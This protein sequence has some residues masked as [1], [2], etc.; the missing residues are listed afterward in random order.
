MKVLESRVLYLL[1]LVECVVELPVANYVIAL[2][3]GRDKP[4]PRPPTF[5]DEDERGLCIR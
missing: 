4:N 5:D 1:E 3:K 2:H